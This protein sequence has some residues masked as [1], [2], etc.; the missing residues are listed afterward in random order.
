ME[1]VEYLVSRNVGEL[2]WSTLQNL[3]QSVQGFRDTLNAG[4]QQAIQ[5]TRRALEPPVTVESR[6]RRRS[7]RRLPGLDRQWG[8]SKDFES[9]WPRVVRFTAVDSRMRDGRIKRRFIH[10]GGFA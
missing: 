2:R 1:Q 6:T 4:I 5:T 10:R 3:E 8:I 9:V 7:P